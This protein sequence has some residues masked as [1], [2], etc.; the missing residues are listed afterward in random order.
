MNQQLT[1][2]FNSTAEISQVFTDAGSPSWIC[3]AL[4]VFLKTASIMTTTTATEA[5]FKSAKTTINNNRKDATQDSRQIF[6]TFLDIL[7]RPEC[8]ET[9]ENYFDGGMRK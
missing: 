8:A 6:V 7:K 1:E 2:L 4:L 9:L 5:S 3:P